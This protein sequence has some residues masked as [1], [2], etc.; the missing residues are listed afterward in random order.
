VTGGLKPVRR[1]KGGGYD[2]ERPSERKK[3]SR[4]IDWLSIT[5]ACLRDLQGGKEKKLAVEERKVGRHRGSKSGRKGLLDGH[6]LL[7][8]RR[9][10]KKSVPPTS[11]ERNSRRSN[12]QVVSDRR[13]QESAK[14]EK[15]VG[16]DR[17]DRGSHRGWR[18][19]L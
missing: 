9:N 8:W 17:G 3:R 14:R 18:I 16:D 4:D 13:S 12:S 6:P 11:K 19:G 7:D 1:T 15:A 10:V 2:I 5:V